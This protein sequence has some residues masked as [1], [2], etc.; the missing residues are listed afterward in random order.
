MVLSEA[1]FLTPKN[2]ESDKQAA[3]E[4]EVSFTRCLSFI[5]GGLSRLTCYDS[6]PFIG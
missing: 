2:T 1:Y 4:K 3:G 5:R 6:S